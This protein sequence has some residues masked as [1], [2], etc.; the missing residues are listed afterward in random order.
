M[1]VKLA[2]TAGFC[3]GV[4][5]A[6]EI[7]LT[8][9]N[10]GAGPFYTFGPLIH[11]KQVLDLL[12]SKNVRS[13][14]NIDHLNEG[15]LLIRAHGIPPEQRKRLKAS[16]LR[17]L[18]ATCPRVARVQAIIRYN[19]KKGYT[20]V[21]I[22]DREHAEV[23]GLM[24]YGEDKAYVINSTAEV[25]SLPEKEKLF[26][27]AQTTQNE[28][29]FHEIVEAVKKRN[30][31]TIIFNT[32]CEATHERQQ[33]VRT[34]ADTVDGMVVV[35]GYNSGNTH[36]LA[37]ISKECGL[38]TFH[39]ETEKDLD[40]ESLSSMNIA[41]VTA[42]A[43]TPNWMIKKVV[44]D[45]ESIRSKKETFVGRWIRKAVKSLLLSSGLVALG[46]FSLSYASAVL[47]GK[48]AP[49][50]IYPLLAFLY[51][52][53]MYVLNRFLDKGASTYNDPEKATF[54]RKNRIFLVL[55]GIVSAVIAL[56]LSYMLG[57]KIYLLM[58]GLCILGIIYS[59]PLVPMS[60]RHLWR[61][62]KIKDIPG[63]KSLSEAL[64][65][66][67]VIALLP[68]LGKDPIK[69]PSTLIIFYVVFSMAYVRTALFDI[70]Q[71]QGDMIVGK[72]TLPITL[73]ENKTIFLVKGIILSAVLLL[74]IAPLFKLVSYFSFFLLIC[75]ILLSISLLSHEK[76]RIRSEPY[77]EYLVEASF[78]LSGLLGLLWQ[79]LQ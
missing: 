3:M 60:L 19:T 6:V 53:A 55:T 1:K 25:S 5:R 71:V 40:I 76:G 73:G 77:T 64:A 26:I 14:D 48:T 7:A 2:R 9:A 35:G 75:L 49:T 28:H 44:K 24:G 57:T 16:N 36:R 34:L 17:I 59:I 62:S 52:Y 10:R 12:T 51:I 68:L 38:P 4:R 37:E 67:A 42:G 43:S 39:I 70:L 11:N 21:I 23:I 61:Y 20:P 29:G 8:E 65:W 30:P 78:L 45:L 56:T 13:V 15:T 27:V 72:E 46:A 32:I 47:S 63:S 50:F 31:D 18:D 79:V 33:E 74:I 22:G 66:A 69:W 54:Y 41:G 58:A